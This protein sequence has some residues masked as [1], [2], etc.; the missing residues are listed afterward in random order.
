MTES[1]LKARVVGEGNKTDLWMAENFNEDAEIGQFIRTET[2]RL[3]EGKHHQRQNAENIESKIQRSKGKREKRERREQEKQEKKVELDKLLG[4]LKPVLDPVHLREM[5]QKGNT[6]AQMKL[7][8]VWH[9][10]VGKDPQVPQHLSKLK[11]WADVHEK[12]VEVVERHLE[13]NA[14]FGGTPAKVWIS[15]SEVCD[16]TQTNLSPS[17]KPTIIQA[18]AWEY[19]LTTVPQ[20]SMA[21]FGTSLTIHVP[22]TLHS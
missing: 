21:A 20:R 17:R 1:Q 13:T 2:R 7:Q 18:T 3:D 11:L 19:R 14:D 8:L 22:L 6:I 5:S 12:L 4:E 10:E 16:T 15:M 9:R